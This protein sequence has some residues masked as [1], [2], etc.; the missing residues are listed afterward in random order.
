MSKVSGS[1]S[2]GSTALEVIDYDEEHN[3]IASLFG[4]LHL[5]DTGFLSVSFVI[6]M[7]FVMG[8][9]WIFHRL[10]QLTEDTAFFSMI[11]GTR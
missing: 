2:G 4:C 11:T 9:E 6:I 3:T 1:S 5:L 10:H 8:I 7:I